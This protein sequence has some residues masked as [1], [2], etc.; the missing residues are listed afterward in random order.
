MEPIVDPKEALSFKED[1]YCAMCLTEDPSIKY[2][3]DHYIPE[4]FFCES[5]WEK[6]QIQDRMI[7]E[8]LEQ[9]PEIEN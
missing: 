2:F 9:N 4:T 5:C 3:A 7:E 8:G 1:M 6:C